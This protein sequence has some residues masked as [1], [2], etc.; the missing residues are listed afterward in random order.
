M[1]HKHLFFLFFFFCFFFFFVF[2]FFCVYSAQVQFLI[3][4]PRWATNWVLTRTK[5]NHDYR[6]CSKTLIPPINAVTYLHYTPSQR[7]HCFSRK[8]DTCSRK[9]VGNTVLSRAEASKIDS[10]MMKEAEIKFL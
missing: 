5:K 2:C 9:A 10:F 8:A 7:F 4:S 6:K 3:F 1:R